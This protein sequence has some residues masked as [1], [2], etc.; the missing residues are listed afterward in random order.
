[1]SQFLRQGGGEKELPQDGRSAREKPE[2]QKKEE[3][4]ID[5]ERNHPAK[6]MYQKTPPVWMKPGRPGGC[7][8]RTLKSSHSSGELRRSG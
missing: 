6:Q 7:R 5:Q 4:R 3:L 2:G 8:Q 1:M